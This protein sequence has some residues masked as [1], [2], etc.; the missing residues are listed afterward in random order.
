VPRR[1][2]TGARE[3]PVLTDYRYARGAL[4]DII[5]APETARFAPEAA[6]KSESPSIEVYRAIR[7]LRKTDGSPETA[8]MIYEGES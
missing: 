5:R 7:F 2:S 6:P 3:S 8:V 4:A 1:E